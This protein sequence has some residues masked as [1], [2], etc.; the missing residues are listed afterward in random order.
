MSELE[1]IEIHLWIHHEKASEIFSAGKDPGQ[2]QLLAT[3]TSGSRQNL[4]INIFA[5]T[6]LQSIFLLH[7]ASK[8]LLIFAMGGGLLDPDSIDLPSHA[9]GETWLVKVHAAVLAVINPIAFSFL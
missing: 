6:V 7:H 4:H 1:G 9:L 8:D 2:A 3:I 5:R